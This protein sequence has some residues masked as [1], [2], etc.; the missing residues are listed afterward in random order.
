MLNPKQAKQSRRGPDTRMRD[1]ASVGCAPGD[2]VPL[3]LSGLVQRHRVLAGGICLSACDIRL[4][5]RH[6]HLGLR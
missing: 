3:R 5:P 1:R 4:I 2:V 6:V